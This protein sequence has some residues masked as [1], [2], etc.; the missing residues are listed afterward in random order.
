MSDLEIKNQTKRSL[1]FKG[2]RDKAFL[3]IVVF[4]LLGIVAVVLWKVL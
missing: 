2:M 3:Q 1:G 4:V